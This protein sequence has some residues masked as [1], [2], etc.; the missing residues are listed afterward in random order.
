MTG[1]TCAALEFEHISITASETS[2]AKQFACVEERG[3]TVYTE[4]GDDRCEATYTTGPRA[5]SS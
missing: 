3:V 2:T 1:H 5:T 4:G